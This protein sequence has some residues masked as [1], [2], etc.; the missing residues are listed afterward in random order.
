M[1]EKKIPENIADARRPRH[2]V[3][4][5]G[6]LQNPDRLLVRVGVR[7]ADVH[8]ETARVGHDV[9]LRARLD[10]RHRNADGA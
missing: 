9:V 4:A 1:E 8:D 6:R 5:E 3:G 7:R 2:G 10:L